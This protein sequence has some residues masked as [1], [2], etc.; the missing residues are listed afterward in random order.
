M[1][2]CG[3]AHI[4]IIGL[5]IALLA[6][7]GVSR[8]KHEDGPLW[9]TQVIEPG[10]VVTPFAVG[11]I[12]A[13]AMTFAP[14]G[15][16]YVATLGGVIFRYANVGGAIAAPP[17]P[18]AVA[19]RPQGLAFGPDGAL[20]VSSVDASKPAEAPRMWGMVLRFDEPSVSAT[21][22]KVLEDIPFGIHTNAGLRFGPDGKLYVGIGS[23][24]VNGDSPSGEAPEIDPLTMA[25]I[26]FD[27]AQVAG[28]PFSALRHRGSA[29]PNP[30]LVD[31]VA[32]GI[33]N[34]YALAFRGDDLYTASNA[35]QTQEPLGEDVLV[36]AR[37]ATTKTFADGTHDD[38]GSPGCLY[39]HDE[40]GWPVAGAS[41]YPSLPDERETCVG[42]TPV[43]A[44]LGLH[45]GATGL[46]IAPE[47]FGAFGGDAFVVEWG[48][49]GPGFGVPSDA[50]VPDI[51][52][53]VEGHKLVRVGLDAAGRVRA[54]PEG[55]PDISDFLVT[56][57]PIDVAFWGGAMYVADF[58][59]GVVFRVSPT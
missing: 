26:S 52:P 10:F 43:T 46:A 8:A 32:T 45:R 17:E 57:A 39:T 35:P 24:S 31:I 15:A 19:D 28:A 2:G 23:T 27:P 53:P 5:A 3:R 22:E 41:S 50:T 21:G 30:D 54:T 59:T 18:V 48:S 33:H 6:T 36:G 38:F 14:D 34:P 49:L 1:L 11:A 20:Y 7:V 56:T 12:P 47:G 9:F 4:R 25:I 13:T 51:L 40:Q 42:R 29:T 16:L 44:A 37:D 58:G 55:A